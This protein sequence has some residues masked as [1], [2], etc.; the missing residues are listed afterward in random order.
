MLEI[1]AEVRRKIRRGTLSAVVSVLSFGAPGGGRAQPPQEA[2]AQPTSLAAETLSPGARRAYAELLKL[3]VTTC[4][5][6]L[7]PEPAGAPGTLL[8]A[9][10]ADFVELLISQ[11]ASRYEAAVAAQE[12]RLA[13][14]EGRPARCATTRWSKSGCTR[15]WPSWCFTTRC[16]APGTCARR[17]C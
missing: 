10:C 9:D 16:A 6:L 15:R 8:V 2:V 17:P 1:T 12:L 4:R 14:L 11:D 7:A 3:K 13:T 5:Q